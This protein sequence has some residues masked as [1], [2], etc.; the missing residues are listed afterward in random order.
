[1]LLAVDDYNALYYRT[2]YG[3]SVPG[4][5]AGRRE[6]RVEELRLAAGLRLLA[7]QDLG[8]A[9]VVCAVG[10]SV[11]VP[12]RVTE[13]VLGLAG[14]AQGAAQVG[15][16]RYSFAEVAHAVAYYAD[17]GVAA[18][19]PSES[20]VRKLLMLTSGNGGEVRRMACRTSLL[21]VNVL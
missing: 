13:Q 9:A 11:G 5:P 3:T 4:S 19:V 1:V 6:L 14:Q 18:E 10:H 7:R 15:V 20:Q 12:A 16:P 21:D 17:A 8:A 2:H